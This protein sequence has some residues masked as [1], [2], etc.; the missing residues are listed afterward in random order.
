M[1]RRIIEIRMMK[2]AKVT[3]NKKNFLTLIIFHLQY[4]IYPLK[5]TYYN[6]KI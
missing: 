2:F 5:K 4:M 3:E 1:N 6:L